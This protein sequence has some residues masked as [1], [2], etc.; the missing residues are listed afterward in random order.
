MRATCLALTTLLLCS[1]TPGP[2]NADWSTYLGDPGRR[3]YS[4]LVQ[5]NR[6]NVH[7]LEVAWVYDSGELVPGSRPVMYTSPLVIDGVLYGGIPRV[8]DRPNVEH[9]QIPSAGLSRFKSSR[10]HFVGFGVLSVLR[11]TSTE[12]EQRLGTECESW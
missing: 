8:G 4:E 1:C 2:K 6:D 5:I 12:Q 7:E 11:D 3:H 10:I 9:E